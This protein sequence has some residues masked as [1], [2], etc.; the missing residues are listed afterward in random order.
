MTDAVRNKSALDLITAIRVRLSLGHIHRNRAG[1]VLTTVQDV[2]L[3]LLSEGDVL[4][5]EPPR[6]Q[7]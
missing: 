7:S 1:Q 4:V 3:C 2:V 5:E 6:R